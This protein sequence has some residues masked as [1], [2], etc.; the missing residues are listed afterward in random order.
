MEYNDYFHFQCSLRKT[1]GDFILPVS[2]SSSAELL[3]RYY[4]VSD[5]FCDGLSHRRTYVCLFCRVRMTIQ[6]V[7]KIDYKYKDWIHLKVLLRLK[8]G[9][10]FWWMLFT[11][12]FACNVDKP[13][14][15]NINLYPFH[16]PGF[17]TYS[18]K[19]S[20]LWFS[21]ITW[22]VKRD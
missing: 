14:N 20:D 12:L 2:S 8:F 19:T 5:T 18:L 4:L 16:A 13:K 6:S 17:F 1:Y 15:I 21:D 22:V 10:C 9:T 11:I 7:S 3:S